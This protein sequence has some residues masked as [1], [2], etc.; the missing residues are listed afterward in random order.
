MLELLAI[1]LLLCVAMLMALTWYVS[2]RYPKPSPL[3]FVVGG[4]WLLLFLVVLA[5]AVGVPR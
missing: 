1:Y 5:V 2:A 3:A 4:F